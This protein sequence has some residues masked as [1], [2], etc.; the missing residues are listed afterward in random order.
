MNMWVALSLLLAFL[1]AIGVLVSIFESLPAG[2]VA[3]PLASVTVATAGL[4]IF[5]KKSKN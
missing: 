5:F 3:A 4:F 1:I 2:Q